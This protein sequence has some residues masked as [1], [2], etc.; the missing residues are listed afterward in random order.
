MIRELDV[1]NDF[2]HLRLRSKKN[3]ILVYPEKDY[4]LIVTQAANAVSL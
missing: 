2:T 1:T 4:L 3:E